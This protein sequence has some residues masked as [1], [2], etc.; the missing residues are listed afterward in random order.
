MNLI[1]QGEF[2][3]NPTKTCLLLFVVDLANNVDGDGNGDGDGDITTS[4]LIRR[5]NKG[6]RDRSGS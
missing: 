4:V 6:K 2:I 1:K 5:T 3:A